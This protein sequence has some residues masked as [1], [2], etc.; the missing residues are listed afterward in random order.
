MARER[1]ALWDR[2]IAG[3]EASGRSGRAPDEMVA[4]VDWRDEA[5]VSSVVA[6]NGAPADAGVDDCGCATESLDE[7][8]GD[9]RR[10]TGADVRGMAHFKSA[11]ETPTQLVSACGDMVGGEI[12]R[13]ELM[14]M[15]DIGVDVCVCI[16]LQNRLCQIV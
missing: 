14:N 10:H 16:A 4:D 15:L 13:E 2:S 1:V 12:R 11:T 9:L 7:G 8:G 6:D 3:H 5:S